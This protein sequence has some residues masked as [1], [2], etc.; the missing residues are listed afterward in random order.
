V[1][2]F[3]HNLLDVEDGLW[4]FTRVEGV[5]PTNNFMERLLSRAVLWRRRSFG[6][7][8][9]RGCR[10]V[11]RILTV[12]QTR[13]LQGKSVLNY[14]HDALQA[15]RAGQPYPKLL[16]VGERLRLVFVVSEPLTLLG[17]PLVVLS[18]SWTLMFTRRSMRE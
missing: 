4:T 12:V 17:V 10:F 15:H 16:D 7:A 6:C 2:T 5:E 9:E 13:R 14:L 18:Y 11:E 1:V 3:C 8:S